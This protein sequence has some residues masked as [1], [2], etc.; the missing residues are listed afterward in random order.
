MACLRPW[1]ASLTT[2]WTPAEAAGDQPPQE[3][4]PEGAVLAG[5]HVQPQ[6]LPLARRRHPDGDDHG[7][8]DHP[9]VVA[10][11][12]EGRVQPDVGVGPGEP[13][14]AEALH[15]LVQGLAHPRD[16]ALGDPLQAQRL[17]QLV[18]PPGGDA[19][20]VGLLDDG[21]QRPL[22]PPAGLQ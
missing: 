20:H 14:G 16:L 17:H 5:A 22:R 8:R 2:S 18:H 9:A 10:H 7:H 21:H 6:H 3:G 4:Q 12:D 13:P 19:L 1:W 15:L 11:L